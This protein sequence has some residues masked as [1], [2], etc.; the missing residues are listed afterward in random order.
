MAVCAVPLEKL[1]DVLLVS[2]K[3]VS[4]LLF[5]LA[6]EIVDAA[7]SGLSHQP[8]DADLCRIWHSLD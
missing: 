6:L 2:A 3:P 4:R 5:R 7:D 8:L 1:R